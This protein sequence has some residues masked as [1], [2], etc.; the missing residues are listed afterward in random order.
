MT[1]IKTVYEIA[2]IAVRYGSRAGKFT[3]GQSTFISRF[4]PRY[5]SDVRTVLKGASTVTTGG[6]VSD[7]IKDYMLAD[8]SPGNGIQAPFSREQSKTG[9]SYKARRGRASGYSR[10]YSGNKQCYP[11]RR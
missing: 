9:Q 2:K 10:R 3:S 1:L 6:I 5:R 4:P 7:I 8:D 11:R